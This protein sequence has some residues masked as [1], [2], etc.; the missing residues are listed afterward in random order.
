MKNYMPLVMSIVLIG[1]IVFL[2]ILRLGGIS[3]HVAS[4]NADIFFSI[5]YIAWIL[6][7]MGVSKRE[8]TQGD[9]TRDYGTCLLYAVGQAVLFLSALLYAPITESLTL[10]H[11]LGLVIFVSGVSFRQWAIRKLGRYYSHIVREV[12]DHR[13]VKSGPY[14]IVRHPAYLGM[15][16][17]NI[18]V[19]VFFFNLVT[20]ALFLF[21]LT[22]AIILRILIEE[23]T[24]YRMD[25]YEAY[26]VEKKRLVPGIW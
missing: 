23:R 3:F 1:L 25:G 2:S 12:E 15:I 6:V 16:V 26:A 10:P 20:L 14:R 18:G 8:T 5:L 11:A 24:L 17:A 4:L 22:P 21:L 7:E 9:R 13:I 19:V